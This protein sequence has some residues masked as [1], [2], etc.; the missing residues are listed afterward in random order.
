MKIAI[1]RK[2]Q[3]SIHR[4]A[5][6]LYQFSRNLIWLTYILDGLTHAPYTTKYRL[7]RISS[8]MI[9]LDILFAKNVSLAKH[10]MT[11]VTKS[12][13]SSPQKLLNRHE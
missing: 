1:N 2:R 3:I 4:G 6:T 11:S 10:V 9:N 12:N 13:P 8:C 7:D 5:E